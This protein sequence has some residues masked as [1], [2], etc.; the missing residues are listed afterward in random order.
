M[1]APKVAGVALLLLTAHVFGLAT[2][3]SMGPPSRPRPENCRW[4]MGEPRRSQVSR[5]KRFSWVVLQKN[6]PG[7][8]DA[9]LT[10]V[11]S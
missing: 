7:W 8:L 5:V 4:S 1:W 10:K 11:M 2:V 9:R 3:L 6:Q